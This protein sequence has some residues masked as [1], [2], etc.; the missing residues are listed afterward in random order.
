MDSGVLFGMPYYKYKVDPS[1][2]NKSELI[3][4]IERNYE[5]DPHRNKWDNVSNFHHS[6]NDGD[7]QDFVTINYDSLIPVYSEIVHKF[8][9]EDL[10]LTQPV[11]WKLIIEN[12]TCSKGRQN[13]NRHNHL[14]SMFSAIHYVKF[15]PEQHLG[16]TFH[17]GNS[18]VDYLNGLCLGDE[19]RNINYFSSQDINNSW[20]YGTWHLKVEEDDLIIVPSLLNHSVECSKLLHTEDCRITVAFN[21]KLEVLEEGGNISLIDKT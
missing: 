20:L 14:P 21:I 4:N 1:R 9:G 17:N 3:Q 11:R 6:Y 15:N 19:I 12:Y 5:L 8:V 2:Y 16:T 13:M 7:N 10:N 18:Y